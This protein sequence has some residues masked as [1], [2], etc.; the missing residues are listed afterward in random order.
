MIKIFIDLEELNSFAAE[1]FIDAGRVAI[2]RNGK[3]TVA[4]AGGSTPKVLYKLLASEKFRAQIDWRKVFFFFGDERNVPIDSDES[5]FRMANE[6][7]L[8]PLEI[9]P[10]NVFRWRTELGNAQEIAEK[11]E[12]TVK[13]FFV[14]KKNEFPRFDLILL[15]MGDDGHTASL[16]PFSKALNETE[17]IAVVNYVE[18]FD[19]NRLTLTFPA[20]N[21][22]ANVVF[23]ISGAAK[24]NALKEVLQGASQSEKFPSQNVNPKNGD[25]FW[26]VDREAASLLK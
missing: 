16:F 8:K 7:L 24:A 15:G 18:K 14:L 4:L 3:F 13:E 11:Y 19:T 9:Q 5:N 23:L 22:A 6:S 12:K 26:L 10:E 2:E 17:K 1:N 21:N 25:L 20:I